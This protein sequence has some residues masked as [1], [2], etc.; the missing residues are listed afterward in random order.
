MMGFFMG[1]QPMVRGESTDDERRVKQEAL[2]FCKTILPR[3]QLNGQELGA[4]NR[5]WLSALADQVRGPVI[6]LAPQLQDDHC[7]NDQRS[8]H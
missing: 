5:R 8:S 6:D 1:V 7:G 4:V 3:Y 2:T